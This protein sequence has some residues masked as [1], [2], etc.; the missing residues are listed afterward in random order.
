[1]RISVF[2]SSLLFISLL[3]LSSCGREESG[4]LVGVM[5]RPSWGG[6]NPFGM[7]YVPSGTLHI[8]QSDKKN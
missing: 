6:I 3:L 2:I 5:E 7:V 4:Q 1:M 8:G